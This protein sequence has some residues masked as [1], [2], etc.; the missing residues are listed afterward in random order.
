MDE[1]AK[2]AVASSLAGLIGGIILWPALV[3]KERRFERRWA[4]LPA[5]EERNAT[6]GA[7]CTSHDPKYP[8]CPGAPRWDDDYHDFGRPVF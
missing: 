5:P 6:S 8:N 4:A 7:G 1:V 3:I 2:I